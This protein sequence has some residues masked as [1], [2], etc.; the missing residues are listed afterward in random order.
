MVK[1]FLKMEIQLGRRVTKFDTT[2]RDA[3][4]AEQLLTLRLLFDDLIYI[5]L[6]HIIHK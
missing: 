6:C 1:P 2:R 4:E 5:L 3:V